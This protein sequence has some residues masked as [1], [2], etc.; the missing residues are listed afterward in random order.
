MV[1]KL[2]T[3]SSNLWEQTVPHNGNLWGRVSSNVWKWQLFE[4]ANLQFLDWSSISGSQQ[5]I[6]MVTN[7]SK[8]L[9]HEFQS[10]GTGSAV[11]W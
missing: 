3:V 10:V 4:M 9:K 5:V 11:Q 2:G 8:G 1:T 6:A 7:G